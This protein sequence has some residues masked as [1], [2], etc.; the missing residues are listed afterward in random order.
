[1]RKT[2]A[3]REVEFI[4]LTTEDP[5]TDVVRVNKF[6]RDVNFGFRLGWADKETANILM[7]GRDAIPQTLVVDGGGRVVTHWTGFGPHGFEGARMF[8]VLASE[9]FAG[10]EG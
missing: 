1:M 10:Q 5:R 9:W 8:D 2:Y 4:G 3:G 7:N 6:V